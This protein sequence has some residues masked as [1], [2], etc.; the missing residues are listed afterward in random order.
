VAAGSTGAHRFSSLICGTTD[1]SNAG[2]Y[3]I[4]M[5]YN[6]WAD[7]VTERMPRVRY[8]KIDVVNNLVTSSGNNYAVRA[9]LK[10]SILVEANAFIGT[11][12][13]VDLYE[14][15]Y[16]VTVKD[17]LFSGTSGTT[18]GSGTAFSRASYYSNLTVIPAANVQAAVTGTL[19]AGATLCDVRVS[20]CLTGT[21]SSVKISSSSVSS[22]SNAVSSSSIA[23]VSS[24]SLASSSSNNLVSVLSTIEAENF[25]TANG[26]L[27]TKNAGYTGTGY[28]NLDVAAS[29]AGSW[30]INAATAGNVTLVIRYANGGT[31]D[32]PMQ[33]SRD[34]INV[35]SSASFPATGAWTT[36]DVVSYVIA[37]NAGNNLLTLTS[38]GSDGP[39]LDQ[40]GFDVATITAGTCGTSSSSSDGGSSSSATVSIQN[41]KAAEAVGMRTQKFDL[42][43][44][45]KN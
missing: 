30:A 44:R 43:G 41:N 42:L 17:N 20:N 4:T 25:C 36:W 35:L 7:G 31:A 6:W 26:V 22:S 16:A 2:Y 38:L 14:S 29:V 9:G 45:I 18:A 34:G 37:L 39:N 13:P 5:Q 32:R 12:S 10:S 15:G 24:S 21:S 11:N 27:E 28:L 8:G 23:V 40:L 3:Q 33:I 1:A 19:G